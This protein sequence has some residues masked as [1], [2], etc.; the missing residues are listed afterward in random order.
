MRYALKLF[1]DGTDYHGFQIQPNVKTIEDILI[2]TLV[3]E[4]YIEGVK[5]SNFSYASRTDSGVSALSQVIA[6]DS[7]TTPNLRR[8]NASLPEGI[9][10]WAKTS[11]EQNFN[12][13]FDALHKIYH[14]FDTHD[15]EDLKSI[16]DSIKIIQGIH[17]FKKLSKPDKERNTICDLKAIKIHLKGDT[18]LYEF[19]GKSFLWKMV[20]KIVSLLKLIGKGEISIEVIN[21]IFDNSDLFDPKLKP[22]PPEG[23]LLYDIKYPFTFNVDNYCINSLRKYVDYKEKNF[24]IQNKLNKKILSFVNKK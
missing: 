18:I 14:Y 4:S 24:R 19:I 11:T 10:F 17:D 16:K 23:L 22:A 5:E 9:L 2:K 15:N 6:F 7:N 13:R 8:I 12:P 20:R 3:E 21:K 1:Y